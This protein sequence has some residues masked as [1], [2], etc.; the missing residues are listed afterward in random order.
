MDEPTGNID[1]E[2]AKNLLHEC[3][4]LNQELGITIIFVTHDNELIDYSKKK[5]FDYRHLHL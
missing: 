3:F 4:R 1:D 2:S 5:G